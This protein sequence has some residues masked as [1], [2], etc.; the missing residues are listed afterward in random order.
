MAANPTS[1]PTVYPAHAF[2]ASLPE[3]RAAGELTLGEGGFRFDSDSSSVT[4]PF[5][6][7]QLTLGG[8][9]NRLVFIAHP[10]LPEWSI[11]T[12]ERGILRDPRVLQHPQLGYAINQIRGQRLRS[13]GITLTLLILVL[14]VP[15]AL[16]LNLGGL[17]RVAARQ[18]PPEWEE[19]LGKLAFSQVQLRTTMLE[20]ARAAE[21]LEQLTQRLTSAVPESKYKFRFYIARDPNINAF[22][23]PGGY[24]VVNS[25][26]LVRADSAEELLGVLAH[27]ISHVTQQH[28]TRNLVASAGLVLTL[29]LLIGDAGGV[30]GTL[31]SAAPFLL[32]Q[33]YSRGFEREADRSGYQ[34]L[35]GA[36]VNPDGLV[37]F[38]EKLKAE[39][40][41]MR[42]KIRKQT[43]DVG[44]LLNQLPEFMST[45]PTTDSRI[46]DLRQMV[47]A[48]TGAYHDFGA[49]FTTLKARV[50]AAGAAPRQQSSEENSD[51]DAN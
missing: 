21:L 13:L 10:A 47:A 16:L 6:G 49:T 41:R 9:G 3:G 20:D 2:H 14:A 48:H 25:E 46:A 19:Q 12:N 39:E 51:E 42:E 45:H 33:K 34:L 50:Q 44:E 28:G 11:Y 30:L 26:L 29:Q 22:A 23:L 4:V 15:A 27:E 43:G 17:T 7:A 8:A 31:A 18:V 5:E 32:T 24:V 1:D 36:N 35:I 37:S 38:F 40:A